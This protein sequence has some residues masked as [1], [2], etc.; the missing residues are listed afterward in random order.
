VVGSGAVEAERSEE[1][2]AVEAER[3]EEVEAV[4]GSGA[5]V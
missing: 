5:F 4:V 3:S 1:V 2:E